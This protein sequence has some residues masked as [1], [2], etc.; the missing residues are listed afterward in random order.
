[1]TFNPGD[2]FAIRLRAERRLFEIFRK[3]RVQALNLGV[4]PHLTLVNGRW[5]PFIDPFIEADDVVIY[6]D[7]DDPFAWARADP[8]PPNR[9][10]VCTSGVDGVAGT[11]TSIDLAG[12]GGDTRTF[13][14][15]VSQNITDPGI[16][17]SCQSG[18]DSR[19]KDPVG[20]GVLPAGDVV[21]VDIDITTLWTH[22]GSY[23]DQAQ[24]SVNNNALRIRATG[25]MDD[26]IGNPNSPP[27]PATIAEVNLTTFDSVALDP[28]SEGVTGWRRGYIR[29]VYDDTAGD[30]QMFF[31]PDVGSLVSKGT[32]T[33]LSGQ[34]NFNV[35]LSTSSADND[36]GGE[37]NL[38][39][40][41]P[42]V[43]HAMTLSTDSLGT[44]FEFDQADIDASTR[45]YTKDVEATAD[46][47]IG[48]AVFDNSPGEAAI[49]PGGVALFMFDSL[50]TSASNP[51][52]LFTDGADLVEP[53][54]AAS[55]WFQPGLIEI[56]E[57]IQPHDFQGLANDSASPFGEFPDDSTF[58][59]AVADRA[60]WDASALDANGWPAGWW[61]FGSLKVLPP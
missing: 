45:V 29:A 8:I 20:T 50:A 24:L 51:P 55:R 42:H 57:G 46:L 1:M 35:R 44:V 47:A 16:M 53:I 61:P 26:L 52:T 10:W 41:Q 4:V 25:V 60:T 17:H 36:F 7:Q 58:V 19:I 15:L 14:P 48:T 39:L 2:E 22:S 34:L 5:M 56:V 43:L 6:V 9:I 37:D 12:D 27:S 30:I 3:G 40:G 28:S 49:A 33:P 11:W 32:M 54:I 59:W 23:E 31:G 13:D 38:L 21:T 18:M